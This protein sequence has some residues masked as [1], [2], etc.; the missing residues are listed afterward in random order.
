MFAKIIFILTAIRESILDPKTY[1][2]L[3]LG[4][5]VI[6]IHVLV[7]FDTLFDLMENAKHQDL[8]LTIRNMEQRVQDD[9][10]NHYLSLNSFESIPT[11]SFERWSK[12]PICYQ[13][14]GDNI[15]FWTRKSIILPLTFLVN[16][17]SQTCL[18]PKGNKH[19]LV[20]S[21]RY[22]GKY[23]VGIIDLENHIK[24]HF[25][26][27]RFFQSFDSEKLGFQVLRFPS[28]N[29]KSYTSKSGELLFAIKKT[30]NHNPWQILWN[31]ILILIEFFLIFRSIVYFCRNICSAS[32][33]LGVI[34]F[35]GLLNSIRTLML[36][37]HLP[38]Q[39][40]SLKLFNPSLYSGANPSLG[41]LFLF[42]SCTQFIIVFMSKN[43]VIDYASI[44]RFRLQFIIHTLTITLLLGEAFSMSKIFYGLVVE[45]S[46][47]FNFNYFPRLTIYSFVG[48]SIMLMT[49]Y[50]YFAL[51]S[52]L[53]KMIA[54][55]QMKM[56]NMIISLAINILL[57]LLAHS[58]LNP[59]KSE[60]YV[61]F[62][63]LLLLSLISYI[64]YFKGVISSRFNIALFLIFTSSVTTYLLYI[65]NVRKDNLVLSSVASNLGFGRD[66]KLEK[67]LTKWLEVKARNPS[68]AIDSSLK[69]IICIKEIDEY[70]FQKLTIE[71]SVLPANQLRFK[72][73]DGER[74]YV[75]RT[76]IDSQWQF[77]S[78]FPN[79]YL[80]QKEVSSR[81]TI[82]DIIIQDNN[83]GYAIYQNDSLI[84][85][86]KSFEF[87]SRFKS[88]VMQ[89]QGNQV[90]QTFIISEELK[91]VIS[92]KKLEPV[93]ILTQF[94]Y[95]FSFNLV[96]YFATRLIYSVINTDRFERRKKSFSSLSNKIILFVFTFVITIFTSI[97][98]L[99]HSNLMN[100]FE[101]YNQE[102]LHNKIENIKLTLQNLSINLAS[103]TQIQNYIKQVGQFNHFDVKLYDEKSF[104]QLSAVSTVPNQ[105]Y[106]DPL[107]FKKILQSGSR[108]RSKVSR[109]SESYLQEIVE[110][111]VSRNSSFHYLS[112]SL[113]SQQD[114]Q[115]DASKLIV[116]LINLYVI[117]FFVSMMIALWISN[118]ITQPLQWIADRISSIEVTQKNEYLEY[119]NNDEIGELVKKYNSMLD[120]IATK[121]RELVFA[122][123]E[124][125][126]SQMA[127]QIAHEI[128]NPLTPMKLKIQ[129]LQKKIKEGSHDI[130]KLTASVTDTLLEQ[131]QNLDTIARSFS[132]F[133]K[134]HEPNIKNIDWITAINNVSN[135]FE[136]NHVN[137]RFA[138][139]LPSAIISCDPDQMTSCL[140]NI[141][142]NAIQA[143]NDKSKII[144]DINLIQSRNQ[145][146][147]QIQDY[148]SGIPEETQANVFTPNFTTKSSG[149]GLGM[150]ITKKII[151]SFG[152]QIN[153]YSKAGHGATFYI[154]IPIPDSYF[155]EKK[156]SDLEQTWIQKGL[157]D[158]SQLDLVI[159]LKYASSNNVF[160]Q[161]L[162]RDFAN[163]FVTKNT[164]SKLKVAS[165]LLKNEFSDYRLIVWDALRPHSIHQEIWDTYQGE[166]KQKYIADPSK[167]SMHNYGVAIDVGLVKITP[168][169]I[170][171]YQLLD[172]GCDFDEFTEI[173]HIDYMM[174]EETQIDNRI[175]LSRIMEKAGF[176][177]FSHEWWHFESE[178]KDLVRE[179]YERL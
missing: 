170:P 161:K 102:R 87:P 34:L 58:F 115:A 74:F 128:K 68:L 39:L 67:Q 145:Y 21:R 164:F 129:Y 5:G 62:G 106:L 69:K 176:N 146:I 95:L 64:H 172:F 151:Q 28:L 63:I 119:P 147:L 15:E 155:E 50:N 35:F 153:F 4:I 77:F 45:S 109:T 159:D 71:D 33:L 16:K 86:S 76:L 167:S 139:D 37:E 22:N 12:S 110:P 20:T 49:F 178:D 41:D 19:Y 94:S 31:L 26:E 29:S 123:R 56:T 8:I 88:N 7:P 125:A 126:W 117:L 140:N 44:R 93:S 137:I 14:Y 131:I 30:N 122:E 47:W 97:A 168:E 72:S 130:G 152:G 81:R 111:L 165:D 175:L 23:Y 24:E 59:F 79:N 13:V 127:K 156:Y 118:K 163:A 6:L 48:L 17:K 38:E 80:N 132:E 143:N 150:A 101:E 174:L 162:Y 98:L 85:S 134:L 82:A 141:I 36:K 70:Q 157:L 52:F 83:I 171:A 112:L 100:K 60:I 78:I 51:S 166:Q 154:V 55:F 57:I 96:L 138:T 3:L 9:K 116:E 65:N 73:E 84:E 103:N 160:G 43:L 113:I 75:F 18:F 114:S 25:E 173:A 136:N 89:N 66:A 148:G 2:P 107:L 142:K 53:I 46:V 99:T 144:I 105:E 27:T 135:V 1:K 177:S 92:T 91:T 42:I 104:L 11:D 124:E 179:K 133:A 10:F 61:L 108:V 149:S 169:K 90:N 40:Y 54:R 32:S 121:T 120:Q 158:L